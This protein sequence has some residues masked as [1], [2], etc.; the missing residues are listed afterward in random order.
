MNTF[1]NPSSIFGVKVQTLNMWPYK[2]FHKSCNSN[3][4]N[5][6]IGYSSKRLEGSFP[7][8]KQKE[9]FLLYFHNSLLLYTF[10][11]IF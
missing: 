4:N 6:C 7:H 8:L 2:N 1:E 10:L 3:L 5:F 9:S 11:I